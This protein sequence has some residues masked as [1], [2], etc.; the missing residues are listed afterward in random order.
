[1]ITEKRCG[2]CESVK[3]VDEFIRRKAAKDGLNWQCRS[4]ASNYCREWRKNNPR[5][6][7]DPTIIEKCCSSCNRVKSIHRFYRCSLNKDGLY[8]WCKSCSNRRRNVDVT[9]DEKRCSRCRVIKSIDNFWLNQ[10]TTSGLSSQC[11]ECFMEHDRGRRYG[12]TQQGYD[13]LLKKQD[14]RCPCGTKGNLHI[15]HDHKT[16][17]V[18]GLLCGPCNRTIGMAK[19]SPERLVAMAIYLGEAELAPMLTRMKRRKRLR[20][21]S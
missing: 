9:V 15:D 6:G 3:S 4:C 19:D 20:A 1:M 7:I 5:Y 16:G 10:C 21:A 8:A 2:K 14:G 11:K 13:Q 18:R 12:L 17:E